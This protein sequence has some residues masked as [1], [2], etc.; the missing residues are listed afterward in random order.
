MKLFGKIV[1]FSW[2]LTIGSCVFLG[3]HAA[4]RDPLQS[5][6]LTLF[7]YVLFISGILNFIYSIT[8]TIPNRSDQNR[9]TDKQIGIDQRDSK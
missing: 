3:V 6:A 4:D 8:S 5:S 1:I 7:V 9:E 2:C